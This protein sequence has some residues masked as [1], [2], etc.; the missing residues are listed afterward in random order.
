MKKTSF[1]NSRGLEVKGDLREAEGDKAVVMAHGLTGD[2]HENGYFDRVAEELNSEGFTVM[3][4]DFSG[5]GLTP[6]KLTIENGVDDLVNA[7]EYIRDL[8]NSRVGLYGYSMGGLI[9]LRTASRKEVDAMF[10]TS[11]VTAS[12][13][14][15]GGLLTD[16]LLKLFDEVPKVELGMERKLNWIG[17]ELADE[18]LAV[19]QEELLSGLGTPVKIV[20]GDRDLIVDV[21]NSRDAERYLEDGEV[22]IIEGMGHSYS[23][24]EIEELVSDAKLWFGKH[25]NR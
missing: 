21:E 16:I 12:F 23:D 11:P 3:N 18:F 6:G 17:Q 13:D 15:P 2:R 20:H 5:R 7:I 25:L 14:L 22:E 19:D 8:G 4:I 24:E 10:L 1:Q 9:S